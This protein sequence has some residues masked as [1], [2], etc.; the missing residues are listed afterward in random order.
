MKKLL[1]FNKLEKVNVENIGP[2]RSFFLSTNLIYL[3]IILQRE[4]G[5]IV[6]ICY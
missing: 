3:T 5:L 1:G 4:K 2:S 6:K